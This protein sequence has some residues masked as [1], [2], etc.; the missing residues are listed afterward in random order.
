VLKAG[1]V[2][3]HGNN[4]SKNDY[5]LVQLAKKIKELGSVLALQSKGTQRVKNR[6][7]IER[8]PMVQEL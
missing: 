3:K 7:A 8:N 6:L 4:R 2:V 5:I 1:L